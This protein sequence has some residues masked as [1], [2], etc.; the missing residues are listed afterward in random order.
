L[1]HTGKINQELYAVL[2]EQNVYK[3][4]LDNWYTT[5]KELLGKLIFEI[6]DVHIYSSLDLKN[7]FSE[8]LIMNYIPY[9]VR[10]IE[11]M[12]QDQGLATFNIEHPLLETQLA[13]IPEN[14]YEWDLSK[15]EIYQYL[16]SRE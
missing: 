12:R 2:P 11:K 14:I 15:D 8:I 13:N 7:K 10:L 1:Y 6:C 5:D 16:L 4:L 9:D 3:K